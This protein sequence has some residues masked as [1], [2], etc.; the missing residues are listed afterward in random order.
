MTYYSPFTGPFTPYP[1]LPDNVIVTVPAVDNAID[2]GTSVKRY[3]NLWATDVHS[4]SVE[5]T[6]VQ[7][8]TMTLGG[9]DLQTT[10]DT[11]AGT[12]GS[13]GPGRL[14]SSND[15]IG[16]IQ[17]SGI[18]QTSVAT[19]AGTPFVV[20]HLVSASQ[21]GGG[22]QIQDGGIDPLTVVIHSGSFVNNH[23]VQSSGTTGVVS[24]SGIA[25]PSLALQSGAFVNNNVLSSSGTTGTIQDSGIASTALAQKSGAFVSGNILSS[26]GTTGTMQDSTIA[27][28][29]VALKT[30]AFVNNR[31]LTSSGTTGTIQ[32]SGV[33]LSAVMQQTGSF[34]SGNIVV[35]NGPSGPF[36]DS[37]L[38][39]NTVAKKTGAFVNNN[40]L[41]SNSTTGTIQDAGY[42]ANS[43]VIKSGSTTV[44]N[45]P[46]FTTGSPTT[47]LDSGL[48]LS[49][50]T[51]NIFSLTPPHPVTISNSAAMTSLLG[52]GLGSLTFA[53]LSTQNGTILQ[54]RAMTFGGMAA[55]ASVTFRMTI[56][57]ATITTPAISTVGAAPNVGFMHSALI[58]IHSSGGSTFSIIWNVTTSNS[59]VTGVAV[60]NEGPAGN[61]WDKTA[62]NSIDFLAQ[63]GGASASNTMQLDSL[64][65]QQCY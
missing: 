51:R 57:G 62:V 44:G 40:A 58:Q 42:L 63:F 9:N 4:T 36:S 27:S 53:S 50:F 25:I 33:L 35:A 12:I 13:F 59:N 55:L 5:T 20:G 1:P 52:P 14:L 10:L 60:A 37:L 8:D 3:R 30:G 19:T 15:S 21:I 61:P 56:G 39:A 64:V 45:F 18:N 24:D 29:A 41:S 32:D 23:V 6:T 2:I 48:N 31:V 28:T 46:Q 17:D 22:G 47:V 43:V 26:S 65:C 11:K 49:S 34:S 16:T 38:A 54:L 7:A